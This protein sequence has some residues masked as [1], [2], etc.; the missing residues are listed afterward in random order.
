M[1]VSLKDLPVVVVVSMRRNAAHGERA[2]L[3]AL[4]PLLPVPE[5]DRHVVRASE[6]KALRRVYG[7]A[8]NVVGVR[9]ERRHLL[10]RVVVEDAQ[11]EVVGPA[12][13]PVASGDEPHAANGNFGHLERFDDGLRVSAR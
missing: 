8:A 12:D 6:D 7:E 3:N 9:L 10:P 5:L 13:E 1:R 11:V 4:P 2:H